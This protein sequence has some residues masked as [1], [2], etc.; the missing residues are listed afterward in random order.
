[1]SVTETTPVAPEAP[2]N[3]IYLVGLKN[4]QAC[5]D[6]ESQLQKPEIKEQLQSKYGTSDYEIIYPE[7]ENDNG[8]KA[9]NICASLDKFYAPMLT[10]MKAPEKE[11][12]KAK[13]CL[14]DDKLEETRCAIM[15]ELPPK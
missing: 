15:K 9:I 8:S 2:K 4:C 1:M 3:H 14:V 7:E 5:T 13:V 10:V 12:D 6:M 11:G